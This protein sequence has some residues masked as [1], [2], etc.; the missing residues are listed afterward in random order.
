MDAIY[1]IWLNFFL[2]KSTNSKNYLPTDRL[3]VLLEETGAYM[4]GALVIVFIPE[5]VV[6]ETLSH[7]SPNQCKSIVGIKAS[8]LY[9][10]LTCQSMPTGLYMIWECDSH[11]ADWNKFR[12]F[13]II[14]VQTFNGLDH[15]LKM[16]L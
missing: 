4:A 3:K 2:E 13:E 8:Q 5:A 9:M 10:Y 12:F 6:N 11:Q 16:G 14:V 1:P 15:T 7:R